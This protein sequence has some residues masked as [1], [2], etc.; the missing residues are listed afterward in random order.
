MVEKDNENNNQ[1][2]ALSEDIHLLGD[3][4][5]QVLREQHG[6]EAFDLEERV[7][8]AA[9]ARREGDERAA[10]T[11]VAA[12]GSADLQAKRVLTKAFSNYFQLVNIAEDQQRIRVLRAR[13]AR[14]ELGESV[15]AALD[16]L[17]AAGWGAAEVRQALERLSITLVLTAH[18]TEAKRQEMLI[19]LRSIADLIDRRERLDLLPREQDALVARLL[20]R[21]EELWQT[22]P[23]RSVA[24]SVM[25]EVEFGLYF[26]TS[27]IMDVTVDV[28]KEVRSGLAQRFPQENWA[29]LP[30]F[31]R[32]ASWIGGDRDGNPEVTPEVTVETIERM[33]R[34]AR[35]IYM[36]D[37]EAL[38]DTFTQSIGETGF[39][40][41]ILE[42]V[43]DRDDLQK[44]YPDQPYRQY[45]TLL[46]EKLEDDSYRDGETLLA[47]L[48]RVRRSLMDHRGLHVA[49]GALW[50]LM[51]KVRVF[52]LNIAPLDVREDARRITQA[53]N[54]ILGDL[55][56]AESGRL[57][58][59]Q[60]ELE[61]HA[62]WELNERKLSETTQQI[63][64]IWELVADAIDRYGPESISSVIGSMSRTGEDVL[65]MLVFARA[66]GV[67]EHVDI[68]PLF[69]TIEDLDRG[70]DVMDR[71]FSMP[72]FRDHV[73]RRGDR[74]Q[75]MIGYS[76]S[77][78]DGGYLAANWALHEAM[79]RM[80][81][82]CQEHGVTLEL[83]HGRGG[84]IGRGGGP[85]NR[86]ILSQPSGATE[87]G[88]IRTTEQ[89]EVIAY[90]YANAS[91]ARRHLHQVFHA[92]LLAS[93]IRSGGPMKSEWGEAMERL[94]RSGQEAYVDLVYETEG[95]LDY[96]RQSTPF[97]E[98]TQLQIGSRP[99]K[100][101]EGGFEEVRAIPWVFS[102]MQCRVILPS[103]YGI[104]TA[105]EGFIEAEPDGLELLQRMYTEW[106]FFRLLIENAELDLAKV[107]MEIAERYLPLVQ[108]AERGRK[109][110]ERLKAEFE[111]SC[112]E[113]L[114]VTERDDLLD[115]LPVIKRSI[116]RRN[117]YVDPLN[118]IQV[119]LLRELRELDPEDPKYEGLSAAALATIKGIA[120]GMKTTG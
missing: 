108:D 101:R 10:D 6:R 2:S 36:S 28:Y 53:L 26:L 103:W 9:I 93:T 120:A 58:R 72:G 68:V 47:E 102:W 18:P 82:A 114:R 57:A 107:E 87:G 79:E 100:R 15:P 39:S 20:K 3:L 113:I 117:P 52:G 33:R 75:I 61:R 32:F 21:I 88:K 69:E 119:D 25:D 43:A 92:S 44:K 55:P 14:G 46:L 77:D 48:R 80:A 63:I 109:L 7:R 8:K 29:E 104:G 111:R 115:R 41:S 70:P 73:R 116:E 71:L 1:R 62:P 5:G 31:I 64:A 23:T 94:A 118:F 59:L 35:R 24:P 56:D 16:E 22:R 74:Q 91:I 42:A 84:S 89:G 106:P 30:I 54:E 13:E 17:H 51:Q 112:R 66:Y 67:A 60:A 105:L 96:W 50:R 81:A 38:R 99:S 4:L 40:D 85:T 97:P 86:A 12:I 37:L 110:F 83:F 65:A 78:K 19:K 49:E 45:V 76:D 98:L 90:R 95:F 11:V 27:V 34:A